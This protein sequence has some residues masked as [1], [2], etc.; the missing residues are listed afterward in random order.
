MVTEFSEIHIKKK[1]KT[2]T[3]RNMKTTI[4]QKIKLLNIDGNTQGSL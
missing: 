2:L 4:Y 3:I 1:C